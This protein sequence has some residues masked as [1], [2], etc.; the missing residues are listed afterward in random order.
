MIKDSYQTKQRLISTNQESNHLDSNADQQP[1]QDYNRSSI[2]ASQAPQK[3][4]G[5]NLIKYLD[6]Q[7]RKLSRCIHQAELP[8]FEYLI[9]AFGTIFNRLY[10]FIPIFITCALA[11]Q[12]PEKLT[13]LMTNHSQKY[14][15]KLEE[16]G[17]NKLSL[18][19]FWLIFNT[20][21]LLILLFTTQ[22]LKR[23]IRRNRPSALRVARKINLTDIEKGTLS[24]PSGDTAQAALWCGL[25]NLF[26]QSQTVMFM[27]PLVALGRIYYQCHY[28]G[29]TLAGGMIGFFIANL[30]F[31]HFD[32]IASFIFPMVI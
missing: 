27:V 30:G 31:V 21:L 14:A 25:M 16:N 1:T 18:S 24:M 23:L 12:Q 28:I 13:I 8:H 5:F 15:S 3:P 20:F 11:A 29:D 2:N 19:L 10:C 4:R 22:T 26:F 9:V 7:D 6:L 17:G 32:R